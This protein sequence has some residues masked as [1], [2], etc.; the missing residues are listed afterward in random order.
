ML[1]PYSNS[2]VGTVSL[3]NSGLR[4]VRSAR[5]FAGELKC[6]MLGP[7]A[8]D[9]SASIIGE[10]RPSDPD[11]LSAIRRL[12]GGPSRFARE[13]S[14]ACR[15]KVVAQAVVWLPGSSMIERSVVNGRLESA[16]ISAMRFLVLG[17]EV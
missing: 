8:T 6:K 15:R 14:S 11:G 16:W 17:H 10:K 7:R 9:I 13:E 4:L 5:I 1:H 12:C 2:D 3:M